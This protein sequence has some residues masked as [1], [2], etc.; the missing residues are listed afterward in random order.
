MDST[1]GSIAFG[2]KEKKKKKKYAI[3]SIK[4]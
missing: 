1:T 3:I 4:Y 2:E